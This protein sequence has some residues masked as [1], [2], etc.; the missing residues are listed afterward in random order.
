MHA[1]IC[2]L[3]SKICIGCILSDMIITKEILK[4]S[5]GRHKLSRGEERIG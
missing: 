4:D 3:L 5:N 1:V 2:L